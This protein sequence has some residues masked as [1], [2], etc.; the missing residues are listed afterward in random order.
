M[1][2]WRHFS[3]FFDAIKTFSKKMNRIGAHCA[4][5]LKDLF[6]FPRI[7]FALFPGTD[8]KNQVLRVCSS[9]A[10]IRY[11]VSLIY[12]FWLSI[13]PL[14]GCSYFLRHPHPKYLNSFQR[15]LQKDLCRVRKTDT[16]ETKLKHSG[17]AKHKING[18]Q[19]SKPSLNAKHYYLNTTNRQ[20]QPVLSHQLR[21]YRKRDIQNIRRIQNIIGKI[22]EHT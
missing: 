6:F 15:I 8:T 11:I 18:Y 7:Y 22:Y 1:Q 12:G 5:I 20:P 2:T 16:N 10:D 9:C 4:P 21:V 3:I 14:S 13:M 19:K 17:D